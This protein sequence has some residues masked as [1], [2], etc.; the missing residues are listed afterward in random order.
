MKPVDQTIFGP[1]EGAAAGNCWSACIASILELPLAE[2]PHF[3]AVEGDDWWLAMQAWLQERGL[4]A[5]HF[6]VAGK[7]LSELWEPKGFTI[8]TGDSP[9]GDF[10]HAVIGEGFSM[11]HDP[12]PSRAGLRNVIEVDVFAVLDPARLIRLL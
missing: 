1:G 7:D 12:H 2:V 3:V 4:Q 8:L 6:E 11:I 5:V 9:R 10:L